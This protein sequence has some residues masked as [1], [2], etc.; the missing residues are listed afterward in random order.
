MNVL[1]RLATTIYTKIK[2]IYKYIKRQVHN[3]FQYQEYE[4][5]TDY[6]VDDYEESIGLVKYYQGHGPIRSDSDEDSESDTS[7]ETVPEV[8]KLGSMI[9]SRSEPILAT[10]PVVSDTIWVSDAPGMGP[11]TGTLI[12][13]EPEPVAESIYYEFSVEN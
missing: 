5:I 3:Y 2:K 6:E 12:D 1:S 11:V 8:Y 7:R 9:R 13:L 4:P 10:D